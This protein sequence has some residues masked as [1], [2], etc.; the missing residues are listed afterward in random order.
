MI[1]ENVY[2]PIF[3]PKIHEHLNNSPIWG[4]C[5][6][7]SEIN[8]INEE[9]Y[10]YS[11]KFNGLKPIQITNIKKYKKHKTIGRGVKRNLNKNKK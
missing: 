3:D 9:L 8:N 6:H 4:N 1:K 7:E 11:I 2:S 10:C 5:F